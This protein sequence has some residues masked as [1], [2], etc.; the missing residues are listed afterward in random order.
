MKLK[1][2]LMLLIVANA[3]YSQSKY[4]LLIFIFK[5]ISNIISVHINLNCYA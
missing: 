2:T 4:I 3:V 1:G 5:Y